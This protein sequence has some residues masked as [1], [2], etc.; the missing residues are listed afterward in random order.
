ML[1]SLTVTLIAAS[2]AFGLSQAQALPT[3]NVDV[4]RDIASDVT[5]A[6]YKGSSA[7]GHYPRY[8][9][10]YR[11]PRYRYHGNRHFDPQYRRYYGVPY[12]GWN[13]CGWGLGYWPH[14]CFGDGY[15]GG[16]LGGNYGDS[17][18]YGRYHKHREHASSSKHVKWCRARYKTYNAKTDTFIGKRNKRYRCNSPYDGRR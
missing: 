7:M 1:K 11:P 15:Y 6:G 9:G 2:V 17:Y 16:Y 3:Q 8:Q 4:M 13:Y 5:L 14:G 10:Q 18:Y 12:L